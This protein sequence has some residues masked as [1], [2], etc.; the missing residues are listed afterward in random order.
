MAT[1][2]SWTTRTLPEPPA[3]PAWLGDAAYAELQRAHI[4]AS[5]ALARAEGAERHVHVARTNANAAAT[6]YATRLQELTQLTIDELEP[7]CGS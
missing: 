7:A 4:Q 2:S 6:H 5:T 1:T 3:R